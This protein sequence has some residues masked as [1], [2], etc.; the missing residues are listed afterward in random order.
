MGVRFRTARP[1]PSGRVRLDTANIT[2]P[3]GCQNIVMT[4]RC[5]FAPP[6]AISL[7]A[8][9]CEA[10]HFGPERGGGDR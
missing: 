5:G 9:P 4:G 10:A 8:R 6:G 1:I 7:D 3:H 2:A